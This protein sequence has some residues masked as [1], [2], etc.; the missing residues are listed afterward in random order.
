MNFSHRNHRATKFWSHDHIEKIKRATW[1]NFVGNA[2]D[3]NNNFTT[4]LSSQLCG[5]KMKQEV[6]DV[7]HIFVLTFFSLG[8]TVPSFIILGYI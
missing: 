4:L 2:M 1:L 8:I 7:I 5:E 3:R 6:P